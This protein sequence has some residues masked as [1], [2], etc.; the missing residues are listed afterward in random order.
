VLLLVR[1]A[2][3]QGLGIAGVDRE[4]ARAM[5]M[6]AVYRVEPGGGRMVGPGV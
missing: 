5:P 4:F 3:P 6:P 2:Q 1:H